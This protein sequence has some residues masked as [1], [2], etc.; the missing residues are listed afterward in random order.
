MLQNGNVRISTAV[1]RKIQGSCDFN[2][3]GTS[4][5]VY[6]LSSA[7][8]LMAVTKMKKIRPEMEKELS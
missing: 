2:S 4:A 8:H 3:P 5:P 6:V 1:P 7:F